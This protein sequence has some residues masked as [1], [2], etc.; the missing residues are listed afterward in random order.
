MLF[1][2]N[3]TLAALRGQL[4]AAWRTLIEL[5]PQRSEAR[6]SGWGILPNFLREL[7]ISAGDKQGLRLKSGYARS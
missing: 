4:Q 1:R 3:L 6:L 5:K 2:S 7:A